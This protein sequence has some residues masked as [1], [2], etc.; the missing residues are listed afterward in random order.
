MALG[1]ISEGDVFGAYIYMTI[2]SRIPLISNNS[3]SLDMINYGAIAYM[4]DIIKVAQ[5]DSK[6]KYS[7]ISFARK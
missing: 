4:L 2:L 7:M 6:L 3:S 5:T 1:L